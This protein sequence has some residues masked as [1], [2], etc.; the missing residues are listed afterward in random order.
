MDRYTRFPTV[1]PIPDARAKTVVN[2]FLLHYVA[3]YGCPEQIVTDN[4]Y[5][6]TMESND[7]LSRSKHS[8]TTNYRPQCNILVERLH[9]TLKSA[10]K[11]HPNNLDWSNNL[12]VLVLLGL[13]SQVKEDIGYS[14]YE[15]TYGQTMRIPGELVG[16]FKNIPVTTHNRFITSLRNFVKET[17]PSRCKI[18]S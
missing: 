13:R 3:L 18:L 15:L 9:R 12:P 14:S 16:P 6:A 2:T 4:P 8:K 11:A 5:I 7:N 10:L 1:I 17:S